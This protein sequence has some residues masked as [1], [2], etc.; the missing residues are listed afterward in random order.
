[1]FGRDAVGILA[2]N[3]GDNCWWNYCFL[4]DV[5]LPQSEKN[6]LIGRSSIYLGNFNL[7]PYNA[8]LN[9]FSSVIG[10]ISMILPM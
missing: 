3:S 1:V 10:T 7:F 9:H 8:A 5:F 2:D 4:S 6:I